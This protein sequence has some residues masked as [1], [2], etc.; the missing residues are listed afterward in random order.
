MRA[1]KTTLPLF[2][3]LGLASGTACWALQFV[4]PD[5][6]WL[7][8]Y[9]PALVLGFFVHAA[10]AHAAGMTYSRRIPALVALLVASLLAWRLAI[11]VGH[12]LGGPAPFVNAGALGALV[13]GLGLLLVWYIR[14]L[15]WKI[16]AIIIMFVGL[17]GLAI[18]PEIRYFIGAFVIPLGLAL[19]WRAGAGAW[20]FAALITAFGALGG[21]IFHI[22]DTWFIGG[23]QHD[24][25][26][27]LILFAEWQ[28]IFMAGLA[29]ALHY[30]TRK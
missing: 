16:T 10:G 8:D 30:G 13:M 15:A 14:S 29:L 4:L 7:T 19:I 28:S 6:Q 23:I 1:L 17:A 20:K 24:D 18:F 5:K 27:V 12:D 11:G 21:L 22:L 26:W 3:I 2:F 25:L 9:Y